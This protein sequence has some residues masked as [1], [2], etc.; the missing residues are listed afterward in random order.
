[1]EMERFNGKAKEEDREA[2][3]LVLVLAKAFERVSLPVV[4]AWTHFSFP[5]MI[6]RV[7]CGY[8]EHQKRVQ[9]EGCAAE[10]VQTITAILP[11]SEWGCFLLRDA[12]SEVTKIFLPFEV[13]GLC[14]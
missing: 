4:W 3:A 5:R 11:G 1:M 10:P 9:F 8:F 12:L 2:L 6:L 13:E 7:L 14:G